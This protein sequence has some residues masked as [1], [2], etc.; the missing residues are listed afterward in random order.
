[1]RE[2][3]T[4]NDFAEMWIEDGILFFI[5]KPGV[6]IDLDAAKKIVGDRVKMQNNKAY[7]VFCDMRGMREID[8]QARD[9][10]AKEG[11]GLVTFVATYTSSPVAKIIFNIFMVANQ[12]AVPTRMFTDKGKALQCLRS[13]KA[14]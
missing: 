6:A 14:H 11:S 4:E 9:Y 12:P 10:L 13:L 1:M 2:S 8:R 7:P 3:Y 5:Y